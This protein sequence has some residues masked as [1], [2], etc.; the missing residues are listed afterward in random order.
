MANKDARNF[1]VDKAKKV[2]CWIN[3]CVLEYDRRHVGMKKNRHEKSEELSQ[4]GNEQ[5]VENYLKHGVRLCKLVNF[6][7]PRSVAIIKTPQ[8]KKFRR[9]PAIKNIHKFLL[10][11]QRHFEL[12]ESELFQAVDLHDGEDIPSV[13]DALYHVGMVTREYFI[14]SG[15][16]DEM[17]AVLKRRQNCQL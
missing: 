1:D 10:A 7:K 2:L 12:E 3:K 5:D 11:C 4:V 8:H 16:A 14:Y 17:T 6:I 9:R 15:P 13:I